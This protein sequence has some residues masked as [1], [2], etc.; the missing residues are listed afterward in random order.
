[1][2]AGRAMALSIA[3]LLAGWLLLGSTVEL[4]PSLGVYD[5]KRLVQVWL[6]AVVIALALATPDL[7]RLCA[8]VLAAMPLRLRMALAGAAGLGLLSAV[9][10]PPAAYPLAEVALLA[11]LIVLVV[12][13]AASRRAAGVDFDRLVLGCL[14]LLGVMVA[15]QESMGVLAG[16]AMGDPFRFEY[17][18][19]HFAHPRFY[20]H[21]QTLGVP[22]LAALPWVFRP[23]RAVKALSAALLGLQWCLLF[24]SGGRGSALAL[25]A[26][27]ALAGVYLWRSRPGWLALHALGLAAGAGLFALLLAA[28]GHMFGSEASGRLAEQSVGR[29]AAAQ[30]SG[31]LTL[32]A[33]AWRQSLDHPRPPPAWGRTR[34]ACPCNCWPNGAG[35][36]RC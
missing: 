30:S 17:M 2:T 19:V 36:P 18:L 6:L 21:L 4:L 29:Y 5:G 3:G 12:V 26:G 7:R 10:H 23:T 31:R 33:A 1:M 28:Q 11:L 34:T 16:W 27:L 13:V 32:W 15:L 9:A 25:L 8:A 24:M 20:N 35:P 14:A 22:L